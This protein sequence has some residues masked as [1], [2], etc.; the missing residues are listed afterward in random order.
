[1]TA[2]VILIL[3]ISNAVTAFYAF[4]LEKRLYKLEKKVG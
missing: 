2:V 1:M 4:G 3:S